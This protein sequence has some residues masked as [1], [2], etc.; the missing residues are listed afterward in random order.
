M[1]KP[2]RRKAFDTTDENSALNTSHHSYTSNTS[3]MPSSYINEKSRP[4][5]TR[6]SSSSSTIN[7]SKRKKKQRSS[8]HNNTHSTNSTTPPRMPNRTFSPLKRQDSLQLVTMH[9]NQNNP[10][11]LDHSSHSGSPTELEDISCNSDSSSLLIREVKP[12][13][14]PHSPKK[15]VVRMLRKSSSDRDLMQRQKSFRKSHSARRLLDTKQEEK[16]VRFKVSKKSGKIRRKVEKFEKCDAADVWW[17]HEEMLSFRQDCIAV[18]ED[19]QQNPDY[20]FALAILYQYSQ[21]PQLVMDDDIQKASTFMATRGLGAAARGL[22]M[23]IGQVAD[24]YVAEHAASVVQLSLQVSSTSSQIRKQSR[25]ISK[26]S[27]EF[28]YA[29]GEFDAQEASNAY[30]Q[31][32]QDPNEEEEAEKE[33]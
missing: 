9:L 29:M 24:A 6:A 18:V 12:A 1:I 13:E 17:N 7:K 23:H 11:R 15:E 30:T 21:E 5:L 20:M 27:Q 16:H 31:T 14:A 33:N 19:Y 10:D 32:P 3:S 28:A 22:E 4:P 2:C 26:A 25:I 8:S